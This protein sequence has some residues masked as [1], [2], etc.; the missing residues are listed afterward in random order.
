MPPSSSS[1]AAA[2]APEEPD[3]TAATTAAGVASVETVGA[4]AN[5][6][7]GSLE[8]RSGSGGNVLAWVC[9]SFQPGTGVRGLQLRKKHA[10]A[11]SA[12]DLAASASHPV[13]KWSPVETSR[14]HTTS[15]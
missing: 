2:D 11:M 10:T 3:G 15:R 13:K 1:T 14:V 6:G 7:S 9:A 8:G 4:A 12:S 5:G